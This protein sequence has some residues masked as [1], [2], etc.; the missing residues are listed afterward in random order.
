MRK[1][2]FDISFSSLAL[3]QGLCAALFPA[4]CSML[5]APCFPAEAQQPAK[6]LKETGIDAIYESG[7]RRTRETAEPLGKALDIQIQTYPRQ[8]INGFIERLRTQHAKDRVLIVSQSMRIPR[9]LKALGS[10]VDVT[11]APTGV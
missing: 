8:Y 7:I 6:V 11:I 5:L 1:Q 2:L 10:P 4:L 9:W 3:A